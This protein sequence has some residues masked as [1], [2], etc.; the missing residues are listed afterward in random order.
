M[1]MLMGGLRGEG[2]LYLPF[3]WDEGLESTMYL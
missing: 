3:E 2:K 1:I